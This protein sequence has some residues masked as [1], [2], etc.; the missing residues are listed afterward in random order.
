MSNVDVV[1]RT[2]AAAAALP[3][4]LPPFE[5]A[6]AAAAATA[7]A[8]AA[9]VATKPQTSHSSTSTLTGTVG[10][11]APAV[12]GSTTITNTAI[13][14]TNNYS[15]NSSLAAILPPPTPTPHIGV[16]GIKR[17]RNGDHKEGRNSKS[18]TRTFTKSMEPP[19]LSFYGT[20]PVPLPSRFGSLKKRLVAGHESALEASWGRLIAALRDEVKYIEKSGPGLIPEIKFTDI[21]DD[22]KVATFNA[23]L[24]RHGIGVVKG[25]VPSA[26]ASTW[27]EE[28]K[29][30]LEMKHEYKPPPAQDP[31]CFDFFWTPAQVRSRAHPNVLQAQRFAMSLWN[32]NNDDRLATRFPITYADRIRIESFTNGNLTVNGAVTATHEDSLIAAAAATS[33]AQIAQVDNGSLERWEQDG[34]GRTG[35]YDAIF[36]GDWESYDAWDPAGRINAT[37]DLYNGAGVCS[38]M[39]LFQGILALT[40]VEP[41]MIRL[42]PS[43]KLSTAY[44]LLRPFFT[45]KEGPPP[46]GASAEEWNAY[47]DASNWTLE[48]EPSTI[49]HGA[50]PGHAQRVTAAWHPHLQLDKSLVTAPTLQ[51]GDYIVWHPDQAYQFSNTNYRTNS[52]P[53]TSSSSGDVPPDD[54]DNTSML[55]YTPAAPLT[56][57]NALYLA[58]QRKTF[59]RGH[60]GPDFD[61]T[62]TGLGSEAPHTGRLGEKDIR[63]VGGEEGLQAMGLAPWN[64]SGSGAQTRVHPHPRHTSSTSTPSSASKD[65]SKEPG[66]EK[67][68]NGTG[69]V[70][71]DVDMDT[72][73]RSSSRDSRSSSSTQAEAEV[74][75]LANIILFP[76]RY[77]FYMPTRASSPAASATATRGDR[78]EKERERERERDRDMRERE[79]S[80]RDKDRDK[81][82]RENR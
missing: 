60:P 74:V 55:V 7:T 52:R 48:K 72:G 15:N 54:K 34:Y 8:T 19:V 12:V 45:P 70:D 4:P 61:S 73:S 79:S 38:M 69:N 78:G 31:T 22:A 59:L 44:F 21:D 16:I 26:D 42:L 62:G 75:R 50:V 49:I 41:G 57:T 13:T 36:K 35:L 20:Q 27:V 63:E 80:D 11:A 71:G 46:Q 10:T 29:K 1:Q 68:E 53:Q 2:A 18:R 37:S 51:V 58:R 43:P 77:D 65:L 47:L 6:M 66:K 81:A 28:T 14:N 30:Y 67:P 17:T 32:T 3:S 33:A 23:Q 82:N 76:D 5:S 40:V 56:Q 25:V 9:G 64:L 24:K 39:R